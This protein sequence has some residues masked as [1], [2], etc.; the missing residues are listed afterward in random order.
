MKTYW[1]SGGMLHALLTSAP[2]GGELSASRPG[3][4][5]PKE[6]A[7]RTNWIGGWV[8]SRAVLDTVV[9]RKIPSAISTE[10]SDTNSRTKKKNN[11]M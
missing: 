1:G 8:G 7:P 5:T 4:F 3:H 2:S 9:K 6:R 10:L 11:E